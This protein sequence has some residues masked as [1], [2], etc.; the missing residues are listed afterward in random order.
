VNALTAQVLDL[1]TVPCCACGITFAV[2]KAWLTARRHTQDAGREFFCPNGHSLSFKETELDRVRREVEAQRRLR[3]VAE[4]D[5]HQARLSAAKLRDELSR[6][7]QRVGGG[8]CPCCK[9]S[10]VALRRH[11]KKKHPDY[12]HPT[13]VS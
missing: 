9:R 5:A 10:F 11:M 7:R 12:R 6:L 13:R 2:P 4:A 3:G 1:E 8:A